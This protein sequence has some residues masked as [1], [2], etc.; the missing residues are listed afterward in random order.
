MSGFSADWLRQRAP[1]DRAAR[2][3]ALALRFAAALASGGSGERRIIDL[4]AGSGANFRVL[5]PLLQG[6]QDWLLVDHD[7]ALLEAQSAEIAR[8]SLR[9]GW[10]CESFAAGVAVR[11]GTATWRAQARPLDLSRGLAPLDFSGC[12]A[13]TT[14]AFLDLVSGAWVESLCTLL[15][16]ARR[17]FLAALT[18]DGRREW[19]PGHASDAL[20]ATAFAQHQSRDK[21]FGAA[22]GPRATGAVA[23]RLAAAGYRVTTARSDWQLGPPHAAMLLRM[24]E[25]SAEVARAAN[26]AAAARVDAWLAQRRAQIRAGA[27]SL[28]IGHQDLLALP[29]AA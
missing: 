1:F 19:L 26:P 23:D 18:V 24:A 16:G 13:V 12:D 15:A 9:E 25:E 27:L 4:A 6:D 22:L 5:A 10:H 3:S 8:W 28:V 29:P 21:G 17:P 7:P 20:I 2:D 14:T 11:A